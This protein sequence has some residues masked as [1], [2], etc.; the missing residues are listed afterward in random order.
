[1]A[2][3]IYGHVEVG[4]R[5][6]QPFRPSHAGVITEVIHQEPRTVTSRK[7]SDYDYTPPPIV[8]VRWVDGLI[9]EV[10]SLSLQDFDA[11]I[12]DHEQKLATHLA[13]KAKL[14]VVNES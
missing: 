4:R 6:Y 12:E 3:T 10:P 1:M 5:V 14:E 2:R 11:L 8:K 7:G 9:T 13:T